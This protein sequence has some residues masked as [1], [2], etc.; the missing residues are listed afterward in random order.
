MSCTGDGEDSLQT[1]T[2][3]SA[4]NV[5]SLPL[6]PSSGTPEYSL[7]CVALEVL[8]YWENFIWHNVR[9][10][11]RYQWSQ[12]FVDVGYGCFPKEVYTV[13]I[14]LCLI[15]RRSL[16]TKSKAGSDNDL[17]IISGLCRKK[18]A[19]LFQG[20]MGLGMSHPVNY[21]PEMCDATFQASQWVYME[22]RRS[23]MQVPSRVHQTVDYLWRTLDK[24]W[25][26]SKVAQENFYLRKDLTDAFQGMLPLGLIDLIYKFLQCHVAWRTVRNLGEIVPMGSDASQRDS[27][28]TWLRWAM[29]ML[30]VRIHPLSGPCLQLNSCSMAYHRLAR[31]YYALMQDAGL[32]ATLYSTCCQWILLGGLW[33][34]NRRLSRRTVDFFSTVWLLLCQWECC[35]LALTRKR[36][37][38]FF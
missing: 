17:P 24:P 25:I 4:C 5:V 2:T 18:R 22:W 8:P 32:Q 30:Y 19:H 11:D 13:V 15:L 28:A 10:K 38:S 21:L 23:S 16:G 37:T 12:Y 36:D 35:W 20:V 26:Q 34:L 27:S 6:R 3:K 31:L 1:P 9:R 7:V 14:E 29:A 33:F